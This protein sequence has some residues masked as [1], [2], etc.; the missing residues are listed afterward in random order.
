MLFLGF[1]LAYAIWPM[2]WWFRWRLQ[3]PHGPLFLRQFARCY[4]S[5]FCW[6]QGVSWPDLSHRNPWWPVL[7]TGTL[8][9]GR[10]WGEFESWHYLS[11]LLVC[12]ACRREIINL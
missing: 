11:D 3:R 4:G 2:R 10:E 1:L 9:A 6:P 8:T 7:R 5:I 12:P